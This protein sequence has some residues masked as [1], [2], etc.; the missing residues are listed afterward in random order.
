MS[1]ETQE[2]FIKSVKDVETTLID[3]GFV[4]YSTTKKGY[5]TYIDFKQNDK[6]ISFMLGPSDW[7]VDISLLTTKRKYEFKDLL[8]IP[9]IARW[10]AT[11]KFEQKSKDTH[12][13]EVE[14]FVKFIRFALTEI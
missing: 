11:N 14:W 12:R 13:D 3:M 6:Q 4:H 7:H 2:S 8:A 5:A 9:S 1:T 10:T